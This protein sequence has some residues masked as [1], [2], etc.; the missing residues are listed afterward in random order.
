MIAAACNNPQV[1][2][3]SGVLDRRGFRWY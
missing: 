3:P 2:A 1:T